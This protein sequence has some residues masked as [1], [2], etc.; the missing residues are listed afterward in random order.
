MKYGLT[1]VS[2]P[3][4]EPVSLSEI[5]AHLY[6]SDDVSNSTLTSQIIAA[7]EYVENQTARQLVTATW[8]ASW[9]RFP[10]YGADDIRPVGWRFG[11]IRVPRS[12]L[13]SVTSLKY[14]DTDAVLQTLATS[15]YQVSTRTDP[16]RIA[17][18][19]LKVWPITDPYSFD[20]VRV[21]FVAGYGAASAVP[22]RLKQAIKLLVGHLHENREA[23]ITETVEREIPLGLKTFILSCAV[24]EYV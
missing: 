18:A 22:A 14:L 12:P 7:R 10:G 23:T 24:G 13:Q 21:V 5:K 15:E 4:E 11:T 2:A 9:D 16:G 6:V 17:P 20:S 3:A 19:R 8:E 1:L